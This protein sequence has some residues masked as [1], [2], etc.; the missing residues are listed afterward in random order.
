MLLW[1]SDEP[2]SMHAT[3]PGTV[4]RLFLTQAWFSGMSQVELTASGQVTDLESVGQNHQKLNF[5][6]FCKEQVA[7][8]SVPAAKANAKCLSFLTGYL[9]SFT[10]AFIRAP[11]SGWLH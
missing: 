11:G 3:F 6:L 7:L 9:S 10:R 8:G 5:T 4:L 2:E 1:T